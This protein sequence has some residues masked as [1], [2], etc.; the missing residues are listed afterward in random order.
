[1]ASSIGLWA[2]TLG[3]T[4]FVCGF[5][6]PMVLNPW[7][8]MGPL[9]GVLITGPG[10]ALLGALV[11]AAVV[12]L[13]VRP[14]AART[15]RFALATIGALAILYTALPAPEYT[16]T[17]LE[18]RV[19]ECVP[20][21]SWRDEVVDLWE[22]RIEISHLETPP[23]QWRQTFERAAAAGSV[24]TIDVT[25]HRDIGRGRQPWNRGVIE[26]TAWSTAR[27]RR[28]ARPDQV[29][30]AG[31]CTG[32]SAG[33]RGVYLARS[34]RA[35]DDTYPPAAPAAFLDMLVLTDVPVDLGQY[36]R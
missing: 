19:Q 12:A 31:G 22:Q 16:A 35:D 8:N 21:L 5:F 29:Y 27:S 13:R 36:A 34:D 28:M 30:V 2:L 3:I 9:V 17:V 18:M 32:F 1:M 33:T 14:A 4:G 26:A 23:P 25:R 20:A 6:G 7:A 24:L 15:L 10:G 11:G